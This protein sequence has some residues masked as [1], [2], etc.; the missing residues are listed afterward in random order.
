[1][2][3][4]TCSLK[5]NEVLLYIYRIHAEQNTLM[6]IFIDSEQGSQLHSHQVQVSSGKFSGKCSGKFRQVQTSSGKSG[7]LLQSFFNF[8]LLKTN[9]VTR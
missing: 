2:L 7:N 3:N 4:T 5:L 8:A 1:M 6:Q 9:G